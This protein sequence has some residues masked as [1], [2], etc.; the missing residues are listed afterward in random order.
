MIVEGHVCAGEGFAATVEF[1]HRHPQ[2]A[3]VAW[4]GRVKMSQLT[5]MGAKTISLQL[6][7]SEYKAPRTY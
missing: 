1:P 6:Y 4:L 2:V 3:G 5:S 7:N